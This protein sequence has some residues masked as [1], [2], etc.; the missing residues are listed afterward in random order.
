MFISTTP[1]DC[2]PSID[3]QST[4]NLNRK[5]NKTFTYKVI[6]TLLY[7]YYLIFSIY[8]KFG[9]VSYKS[10]LTLCACRKPLELPAH[11]WIGQSLR[12]ILL[13][14]DPQMIDTSRGAG[15]VYTDL[16]LPYSIPVHLPVPFHMTP[17]LLLLEHIQNYGNPLR[18]HCVNTLLQMYCTN[19]KF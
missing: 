16:S 19:C 12:L 5:R 17:T 13:L 18:T 8:Y 6:F 1:N 3:F 7:W 9:H 10:N 11:P 15:D 14:N 2:S 4:Y